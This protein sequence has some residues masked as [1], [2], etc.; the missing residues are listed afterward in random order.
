MGVK[1][2]VGLEEGEGSA[3]KVGAVEAEG[4]AVAPSEAEATEDA[5]LEADAPPEAVAAPEAEA[6]PLLLCVAHAVAVEH[7]L[8]VELSEGDAAALALG[9]ADAVEVG[10]G[11]T[12]MRTTCASESATNTAL[13]MRGS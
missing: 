12:S 10:V 11:Y 8:T 3:L 2:A 13:V 1:T 9:L 7:A 4:V 5:A 6:E